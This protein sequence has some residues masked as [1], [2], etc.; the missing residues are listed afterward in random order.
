MTCA[1]AQELITA[2]VDQEIGDPERSLLDAH[3]E[4]CAGCRRAVEQE[5]VLKNAIR[6]AG[7]RVRAARELR[8]RIL[9]DP[10]IFPEK[11][12][13]VRR[14]QD[15]LWRNPL[16][17][18]PA[19]VAVL[20]LAVVLPALYLVQQSREPIA[21]AAIESYGPLLRG[22]L[23]VI[24][25]KSADEI[26]KQLGRTVNGSFH[27]MGYDL[28]A[29]NLYPVTGAVREI[30][31]R[32]LL[33]VIYQGQGGSLLCYTFLGSQED[34][35]AVAASF[36]DPDKTMNFYAF[37]RGKVNAVLHREGDVICILVSEMAMDDLLALTRSKARA[38]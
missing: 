19:L 9:S 38:E 3:L 28:A 8:N 15:H 10:R 25:A 5:R 36:F 21:F 30:Q 14:W 16:N 20:V 2:L 1:E 37:S 6:G 23:P 12:R 18:R 33:V 29:M 4:E 11:S 35:P 27:P 24:G 17:I 7:E 22:D 26:E 13:S 31:G 32:K 34:V